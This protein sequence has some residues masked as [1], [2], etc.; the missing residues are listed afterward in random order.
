V[1]ADVFPDD[2]LSTFFTRVYE[3]FADGISFDEEFHLA[4]R[5]VELLDEA[6]AGSVLVESA[7]PA[8]PAA[9]AGPDAEVMKVA[10]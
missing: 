3:E 9:P 1:T 8:A 2:A 6:K 7:V 10:S 5:V 4:T